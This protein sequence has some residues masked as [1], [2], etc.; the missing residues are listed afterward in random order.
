[1]F[2]DFYAFTHYNV[3]CFQ[4]CQTMLLIEI[5]DKM[6]CSNLEFQIQYV[7]QPDSYHL[8]CWIYHGIS[9]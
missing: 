3:H 1:M 5:K 4:K 8:A 7:I 6:K 2:Y 9:L